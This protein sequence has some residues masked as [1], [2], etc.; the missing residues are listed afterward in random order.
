MAHLAH[1][2]GLSEELTFADVCSVDDADLLSLIR[3]PCLALL[4]VFPINE[5]YEQVRL[6]EDVERADYT[7]GDDAEIVWFK[8]TMGTACGLIGLLQHLLMEACNPI[9]SQGPILQIC[10]RIYRLIL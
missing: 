3:R 8:Q 7:G 1:R 9:S 4:L 2:L 10:C 6:S 5:V